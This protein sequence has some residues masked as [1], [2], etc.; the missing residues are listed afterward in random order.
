V[1]TRSTRLEVAAA[2]FAFSRPCQR[3]AF[4]AVVPAGE[5]PP[6]HYSPRADA[7]DLAERIGFSELVGPAGSLIADSNRIVFA[8]IEPETFY[9]WHAHGGVVHVISS[10]AQWMTAMSSRELP[11]DACVRPPSNEPHAM[12]TERDPQLAVY[13]WSGD[14]AS[15]AVYP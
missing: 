4:S 7:P 12:R 5:P 3:G 10:T 15:L 14:I 13:A 11:P 9:L 1:S 2:R 6:R 8:M